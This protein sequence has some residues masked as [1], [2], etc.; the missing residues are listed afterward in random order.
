MGKDSRVSG[1][2]D[3]LQSKSSHNR[4]VIISKMEGKEV[5]KE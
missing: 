1:L 5:I 4:N 2:Q 3:P